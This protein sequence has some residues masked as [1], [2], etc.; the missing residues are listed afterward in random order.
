MNV[1]QALDQVLH[2]PLKSE[3]LPC[4][5]SYGLYYRAQPLHIINPVVCQN[6]F[7]WIPSECVVLSHFNARVNALTVYVFKIIWFLFSTMLV[8]LLVLGGILVLVE[9]Q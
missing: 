1:E 2:Y 4:F 6:A 9:S 8:L 3:T 7:Y 5:K